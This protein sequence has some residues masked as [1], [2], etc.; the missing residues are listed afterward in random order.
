MN[1][2]SSVAG[3]PTSRN[4]IVTLVIP[5]TVVTVAADWSNSKLAIPSVK[6][7]P[8]ITELL[9]YGADPNIKN[10]YNEKPIDIF[11]GTEDEKKR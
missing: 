8:V 4:S 5:L 3:V 7:I 2:G 10:K 9:K 11:R 6:S 1:T